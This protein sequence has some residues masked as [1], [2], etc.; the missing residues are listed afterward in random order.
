[1]QR[2]GFIVLVWALLATF[3]LVW[4]ASAHAQHAPI[5]STVLCAHPAEDSLAHLRMVTFDH[6]N[7]TY[8][9]VYRCRRNGY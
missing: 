7:D 4:N 9:V 1:M 6:D 8:T 3:V 2:I 5:A